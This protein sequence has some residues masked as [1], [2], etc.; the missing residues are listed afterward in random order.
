MARIGEAVVKSISD[1]IHKG[2]NGN[3]QQAKPLKVSPKSRKGGYPVYKSQHGLQPFRDWTLSGRTLR[4][5][6]VLN[7]NENSGKIAFA[8]RRSAIIAAVLNKQER[9]FTIS[10]KDRD[11]LTRAV[12]AELK[13]S[14]LLQFKSQP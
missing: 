9:A 12:S 5:M 6:K 2:L 11:A 14:P 4:G 1:R 3:D 8:D 13:R 10:P 7:V